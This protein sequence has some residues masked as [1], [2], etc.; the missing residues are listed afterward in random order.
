[1]DEVDRYNKNPQLPIAHAR[2]QTALGR[3]TP[4]L[5][6]NHP[7]AFATAMPATF[8]LS[9]GAALVVEGRV[10]RGQLVAIADPSVLINNMLEIEGNR[11]F[12][13]EL[14]AT[15]CKPGRDRILLYTQVFRS[16]GE[17]AEALAGATEDATGPFAQFN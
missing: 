7:A 14:I 12:A 15:T 10:G 3:S 5:V 11:A 8:E 9:P 17:P 13:R 16:Q 1:G 2:L 4:Q 6:A